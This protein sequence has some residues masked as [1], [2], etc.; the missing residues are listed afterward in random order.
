MATAAVPSAH[1]FGTRV[2]QHVNSNGARPRLAG[3]VDER[4]CDPVREFMAGYFDQQ[5]N[6]ASFLWP[7]LHYLPSV[8][9]ARFFLLK[10]PLNRSTRASF[11]W[12]AGLSGVQV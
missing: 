9:Y 6:D 10:Y 4:G 1:C 12:A 8:L 5:V 7:I 11:V 2:A 3:T